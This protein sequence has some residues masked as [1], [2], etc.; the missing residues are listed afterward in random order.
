MDDDYLLECANPNDYIA[1]M[2]DEAIY[3]DDIYF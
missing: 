1:E 3:F 2:I